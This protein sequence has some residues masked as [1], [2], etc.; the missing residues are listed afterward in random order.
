MS[1]LKQLQS[2]AFERR[3]FERATCRIGPIL[4]WNSKF[5]FG[6]VTCKLLEALDHEFGRFHRPWARVFQTSDGFGD[7]FFDTF[8]GRRVLRVSTLRTVVEM[9]LVVP[10]GHHTDARAFA[11]LKVPCFAVWLDIARRF[12]VPIKA[13]ITVNI[14]L[15][16]LR[17]V[18]WNQRH[19]QPNL[20]IPIA[21]IYRGGCTDLLLDPSQHGVAN[22]GFEVVS[23]QGTTP[24][25]F[26][27]KPILLAVR[28]EC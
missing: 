3:L 1:A 15:I 17:T 26:K 8:V 21:P 18:R 25:T 9:D 13:V 19:L 4:T 23:D 27:E 22:H 12:L 7:L 24:F 10:M 20:Q 14:D 5:T 11:D 28:V 16:F 6:I 2:V